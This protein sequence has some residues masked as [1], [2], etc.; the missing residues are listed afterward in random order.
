MLKLFIISNFSYFVKHNGVHLLY[1]VDMEEAYGSKVWRN[2]EEIGGWCIRVASDIIESLGM[3]KEDG[4]R[5]DTHRGVLGK[6]KACHQTAPAGTV[7]SC[8]Q[9][10]GNRDRMVN[11]HIADKGSLDARG[12]G[13]AKKEVA[14]TVT[15]DCA[16]PV[17][18]CHRSQYREEAQGNGDENPI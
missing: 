13:V 7:G 16:V 17:A 10:G 8:E 5:L 2:G 1:G 15:R 11:M 4:G 9:G 3:M 6:V 14:T 12:V 18:Y